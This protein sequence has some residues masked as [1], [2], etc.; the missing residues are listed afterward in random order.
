MSKRAT[1]FR[2]CLPCWQAS[3]QSGQ[4]SLPCKCGRILAE[5][6]RGPSASG[7]HLSCAAGLRHWVPCTGAFIWHCSRSSPPRQPPAAP[8]AHN[9][10][11]QGEA[12]LCRTGPLVCPASHMQ[13]CN[14]AARAGQSAADVPL[15]A[16]FCADDAPAAARLAERLGL[17]R[18]CHMP[19][20]LALSSELW[21]A[22][23]ELPAAWLHNGMIEHARSRAGSRARRHGGWMP[24]AP[25]RTSTPPS[26]PVRGTACR[27]PPIPVHAGYCSASRAAKVSPSWRR[28][29]P[30]GALH[31]GAGGA[32][33]ALL[34]Q[35]HPARRRGRRGA[36]L[37]Q[38]SAHLLYAPL[39]HAPLLAHSA[40]RVGRMRAP[41]THG[42]RRFLTPSRS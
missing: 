26:F 19:G 31:G 14:T 34:P 38:P 8:Q 18:A 25:A 1:F 6:V 5:D 20:V 23:A 27:A 2:A 35:R 24:Q 10:H 9:R 42:I 17:P 33:G 7:R 12:Q 37:R 30:G 16:A 15:A 32:A 36:R 4:S 3:K 13:P 40:T 28:G 22:T 41:C 21:A 29:R 11:V 39:L